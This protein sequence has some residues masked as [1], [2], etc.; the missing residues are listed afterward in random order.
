MEAGACVGHLAAALDNDDVFCLARVSG[1]DMTLV[2]SLI[3]AKREDEQ[4]W[5]VV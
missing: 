3:Q 5:L 4:D 2:L 1:N